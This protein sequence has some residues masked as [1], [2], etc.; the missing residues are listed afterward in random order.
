MSVQ[1]EPKYLLVPHSVDYP[2]QVETKTT[3][4]LFTC[5]IEHVKFHI[6]EFTIVGYL[7]FLG[8]AHGQ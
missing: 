2:I 8:N 7:T 5:L 4:T 1:Y 6:L 3:S